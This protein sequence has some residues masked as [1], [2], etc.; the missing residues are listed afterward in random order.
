MESQERKPDLTNPKNFFSWVFYGLSATIATVSGIAY[1]DMRQQRDE[2]V[3][4][5]NRLTDKIWEKNEKIDELKKSNSEKDEM[6]KYADSTLRDST[7]PI[8]KKIL[9]K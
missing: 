8:A 9:E 7:L 3:E 5:V 2:A 4:R 1:Q 6:I